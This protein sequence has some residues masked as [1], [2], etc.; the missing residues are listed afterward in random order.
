MWALCAPLTLLP[1]I[2]CSQGKQLCLPSSFSAWELTGAPEMSGGINDTK[3]CHE[4]GLLEAPVSGAGVPSFPP[5]APNTPSTRP[6]LPATVQPS[7]LPPRVS[8]PQMVNSCFSVQV[9]GRVPAPAPPS[10]SQVPRRRRGP[11]GVRP[12]YLQLAEQRAEREP[13][14][15]RAAPPG[16]RDHGRSSGLRAALCGLCWRGGR[17]AVRGLRVRRARPA[18]PRPEPRPRAPPRPRGHLYPPAPRSPV[19]RPPGGARARGAA[20]WLARRVLPGRAE[21]LRRWR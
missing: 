5:T 1:R 4:S 11:A 12:A 13:R 7:S 8:V 9:S 2:F 18:P 19:P 3:A 10:L 15:Q 14:G 6:L 20:G 17:R 16:A 21:G